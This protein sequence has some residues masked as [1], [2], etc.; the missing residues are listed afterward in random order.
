MGDFH[1]YYSGKK[2]APV[3]TLV[4]GGNHEA[5]S[6][7]SELHYGGWLAP[8][9]YYLGEVNVL[10]YGPFRIAGLSGIFK[11]SDYHKPHTERLPYD[12]NEIRSIFHVRECDVA[13]LL[14]VRS[15]VDVGLSHD[16]PRRIEWFGDYKRLFAERPHF[17]DSAKMDNLGSAPAEEVMNH[18]RPR[19]WF[20]GHMHIKYSATV[21]HKDKTAGDLLEDLGISE[22]FRAQL[23]K[24]MFKSGSSKKKNAIGSSSPAIMNTTTHFLALD[25]PG[26]GN[27]YIEL[28]EIESLYTVEDSS[29][30][31]YMQ[32]TP[33]GK[34]SLHYDEEWLSTIR[35]SGSPSNVAGTNTVQQHLGWI[36]ENM[37]AKGHLRIPENFKR[38]A[39]IYDPNDTSDVKEQPCEF[40]NHQT[41][42]FCRMLQIQN[43]F[44]VKEDNC[45]LELDHGIVFG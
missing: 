35:S 19:Y 7:F 9:I 33:E 41:E 37:T 1:Q 22:E 17:F 45:E 29:V 30:K 25:K 27:E 15:P 43:R 12:W 4:I 23:P 6:Y 18:V 26:S 20:S 34:F 36:Q 39:P 3:L 5:S 8:N 38:H 13:K 11:R 10:R 2:R 28:L 42:V 14:Q 16:W 32:R 24:S 31:P 44:S 40:P 21:Q